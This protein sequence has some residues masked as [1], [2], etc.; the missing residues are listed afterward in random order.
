M[1]HLLWLLL[2]FVPL[3]ASGNGWT[4]YGAT[5]ARS[6]DACEYTARV[7]G[8]AIIKVS[9]AICANIK[10]NQDFLGGQNCY[11]RTIPLYPPLERRA[12]RVS[13]NF[14][15]QEGTTLFL[16]G[17]VN[18]SPISTY[19]QFDFDKAETVDCSDC[20]EQKARRAPPSECDPSSPILIDFEGDGGYKRWLF[21]NR[22]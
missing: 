3:F 1:R 8:Q 6:H 22:P 16:R 19:P 11:T 10:R 17:F 14:S 12:E 18:G 9:G 21:G 15:P 7:Y 5:I 4:S 20:E 2:M 13:F